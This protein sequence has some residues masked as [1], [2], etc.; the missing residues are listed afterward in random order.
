MNNLP[1]IISGLLK[2]KSADS[3]VKQ[4][5]AIPIPFSDLRADAFQ[6]IIPENISP[7]TGGP[8]SEL[9]GTI[10]RVVYRAL[11]GVVAVYDQT[12]LWLDDHSSNSDYEVFINRESLLEWLPSK[13]H[14]LAALL[15]KTKF[16]FLRQPHLI[17]HVS[18]IPPMSEYDRNV[19]TRVGGQNY[20]SEADKQLSELSQQLQPP[21]FEMDKNQAKLLNFYIWTRTLGCIYHINCK[22]AG[23]GTFTYNASQLASQIGDFALAP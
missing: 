6:E 23:N 20:F 4:L 10:Y 15:V 1:R 14:D 3:K 8:F 17:R 5:G 12:I 16:N 9:S 21:M 22:F 11:S 18:D 2:A 7:L 13:T 19:V